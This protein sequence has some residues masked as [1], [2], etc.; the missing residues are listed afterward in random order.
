MKEKLMKRKKLIIIGGAILVAII[1]VLIVPRFVG[2][3]ATQTMAMA[4]GARQTTTLARTDLSQIFSTSGVVQSADVNYVYSSHSR[5]VMEIYVSVG[6]RVEVGDVLARLDM[7]SVQNEIEQTEINL[8][9]AQRNVEEE[10]RSNANSVAN[11][12]ISLEN[13]RISLERQNMNIANAERDLAEAEADMYEPFDSTNHDRTIADAQINLE[14]KIK[15]YEEAQNDL[16]EVIYDFDDYTYRNA[17]NEAEIVLARRV[18]DLATAEADYEEEVG[19]RAERFISTNLQNAVDDAERTLERRREAI[20]EATQNLNDAW[21][22]YYSATPEREDSAMTV[23]INAVNARTTA[24]NNVEDAEIALERARDALRTAREDHNENQADQRD[25]AITSAERAFT[26]AQ[27]AADDAQRSLDRANSDL[28]RARSNA[29]TDASNRMQS[30]LNAMNDAQRTLERAITD[31]ERAAEDYIANN[32]TR[33]RNAQSSFAESQNQLQSSQNS[34][35]S[36]QE[37]LNQAQGRP[38]ASN[39]SVELQTINLERLSAQLA[40]GYILATANGVITEINATIG[41]TANGV[42]FTI[43]DVDNLFVSAN[44]REHSLTDLQI[45]Q[46]AYVTTEITR[47]RAYGAELTFISPRAVSA[48]GSTS[49]EFEI[50]AAMNESDHNIRIGMNAFINVITA[51]AENVLAVPL[52]AI[53]TNERGS[54]VYAI[55]DDEETE[56][57]VTVGLRTSTHAEISS[58]MPGGGRMIIRGEGG[59][60][61]SMGERPEGMEMPQ[62]DGEMPQRGQRRELPEGAEMPQRGE[63]PEGM[64]LPEGMTIPEGG[65]MFVME[66]P[67]GFEMPVTQFVELEEGMQILTRASEAAANG[68]GMPAGTMQFGP[69]GGGN[70]G[71]MT[72]PAGDGGGAVR[73]QSGGGGR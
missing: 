23:V 25:S 38:A 73:F 71:V 34:Y 61:P 56:I 60:M 62:F 54:F 32:E 5:P 28:H 36:A 26:N 19:R 49:V 12:R 47:D 41:A 27:N 18:S 57:P 42:L 22:N 16:S 64:E 43:E 45:G 44:V 6:D 50:N 69:G 21:R 70:M 15:D 65:E 72:M 40:E 39:A 7:T 31:R 1:A 14:R 4:Q 48:A 68:G 52:S 17:I 35:R 66:L 8:T 46:T 10:E 37:S 2:N 9:S 3:S 51:Q 63:M 24:Q 59:D 13:A 30:A 11:A 20:T 67:D 29:E 53:A 33:F 55:I 58:R